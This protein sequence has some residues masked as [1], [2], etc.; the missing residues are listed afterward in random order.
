MLFS[1][2]KSQMVCGVKYRERHGEESGYKPR[3]EGEGAG[4]GW[5]DGSSVISD[6]WF[7]YSLSILLESGC[8][9]LYHV[10]VFSHGLVMQ[11]A[12]AQSASQQIGAHILHILRQR[13]VRPFRQAHRHKLQKIEG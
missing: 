13:P 8:I 7:G 10:S 5:V 1:L 3:R 2:M 6:L 11:Q 9:G 12:L 4:E